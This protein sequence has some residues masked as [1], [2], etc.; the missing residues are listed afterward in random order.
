MDVR[1][2]PPDPT[3]RRRRRFGRRLALVALAALAAGALFVDRQVREGFADGRCRDRVRI[4][5]APFVVSIGA[6]LEKSGVFT[7]LEALGYRAVPD[8]PAVPGTYRRSARHL[9]IFLHRAPRGDGLGE[10]P[11]ARVDVEIEDGR[12]VGI[13]GPEPGERSPSLVLE[14]R[15]LPGVLERHWT[16]RAGLALGEVPPHVVDAVLAA[17]DVRFLKH[18]GLDLGSLARAVQVNWEAQEVRQGGSTITQQ[19]VKNHFLTRDRTL[20]R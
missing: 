8:E 7:E 5:A 2:G 14:P 4:Y 18:P 6:S 20:L 12:V 3:P 13:A 10:R 17:E 11:A 9:E 16:S 15:Q 19:V 1:D